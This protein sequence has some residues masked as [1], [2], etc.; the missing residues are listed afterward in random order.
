M[1]TLINELCISFKI[2]L[3]KVN[4]IFFSAIFK[5]QKDLEFRIWKLKT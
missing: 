1:K 2:D 5:I 3:F 4:E